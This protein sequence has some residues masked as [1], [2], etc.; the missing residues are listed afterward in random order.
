MCHCLFC[1]SNDIKAWYGLLR[2][3]AGFYEYKIQRIK[4]YFYVYSVYFHTIFANQLHSL[5]IFS[6]YNYILSWAIQIFI[7]SKVNQTLFSS[8]VSQ[9]HN[10]ASHKL[11]FLKPVKSFTFQKTIYTHHLLKPVKSSFYQ[12]APVSCFEFSVVHPTP[13]WLVLGK[14]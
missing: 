11:F 1:H 14:A 4:Y 7:H 13:W 6:K 10:K 8:F 12:N 5:F 9:S 3:Y 2:S